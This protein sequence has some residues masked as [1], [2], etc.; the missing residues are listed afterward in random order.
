MSSESDQLQFIINFI[1]THII[2]WYG[3]LIISTSLYFGGLYI[4]REIFRRKHGCKEPQVYPDG[5]FL[6][7]KLGYDLQHYK[8]TGELI[9]FPLKLFKK[10]GNKETFSAYLFGV[11]VVVTT[12]PEN[13]KAIL[14]TQFN[15]FSL[16]TRHAHFAPLLGDGI[17]T[18][19][20]NGWKDS[21]AMLRPQFAREQISH[22]QIIEPHL[23][24]LKKHI[25]KNKG[26][27][28][29]I[30]ELFFRLT[31]DTSTEFLFGESVH[32]LY[33]DSVGLKCDDQVAG[34]ADAF[35]EAQKA[36]AVRTYL[37][38]LY[39]L[40]NPPSFWKSTKVVHNFAKTFVNKAL[41]LTPS[42]LEAKEKE[43]Y[44]FLYE[45]SKHTR[46]PK[47]L[48][49]QLLNILVAGR[50]TTAGLLSFCFFELSRHPH[51][52]EKLKE[53]IYLHFGSGD[54]IDLSSI[55]FE[56]LKKCNYL[57]WVLNETLRLYP[58]VP[59]N[60]RVA[61]K[62]TTLPLGGGEDGSSPVFVG[63]GT[64]V[65]YA[66]YV[67]QR[68]EKYYGKDSEQFK[69]ERWENIPKLGWAYLPFNGGPRICLGQQFALTEASY[70]I[71]RLAQMYPNLICGDKRPDPCMKLIH[72]TMSHMDGVHIG[73]SK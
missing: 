22:V 44:I 35:N 20:G 23:Q 59:I 64:T 4:K 47:I 45:L 40:Y 36:L 1:R 46:D 66:P 38:V 63:K 57:K 52:W 11:R 31:V 34:F 28:F 3:V 19:D 27:I 9:D 8:K 24:I 39:F 37:Q 14:A 50:D 55:T 62:D 2:T 51:I 10:Y 13:L 32:S 49:D 69:P 68:M 6:G 16:G 72:L 17:F 26:K 53:D 29:D 65:A 56:T 25:D 18:L 43:G 42:E 7:I 41:S 48:Q 60:F 5:G 30:Q 21:R 70:V 73:M 58:S 54:D 61:T 33:D 12:E 67:L 71:V 15:D